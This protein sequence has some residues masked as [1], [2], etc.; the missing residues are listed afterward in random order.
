MLRA[1]GKPTV[2]E[3]LI[4]RGFQIYYIIKFLRWILVKRAS[5]HKTGIGSMTSISYL[6][7][8]PGVIQPALFCKLSV[9]LFQ[10]WTTNLQYFASSFINKIT[11]RN[12]LP[13]C[14]GRAV[15]AAERVE[16]E[17]GLPGGSR[18]YSIVY[19]SVAYYTMIYNSTV[20]YIISQCS[21]L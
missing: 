2:P 10:R 14:L 1:C 19:Y 6:E 15:E 8:P 12:T 7:F 21:T 5:W 4:P 13:A 11:I 20:Y 17:G 9:F 16:P 3:I 18:S